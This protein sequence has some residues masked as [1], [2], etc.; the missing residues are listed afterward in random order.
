MLAKILIE[1]LVHEVDDLGPSER[2]SVHNAS[3]AAGGDWDEEEPSPD[4]VSPPQVF[5]PGSQVQWNG[6]NYQVRQ[7]VGNSLVL[8][9]GGISVF[10]DRVVPAE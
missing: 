5:S 4:V 9:P 7:V 6:R 2:T 8:D 10:S 3:L 1:R